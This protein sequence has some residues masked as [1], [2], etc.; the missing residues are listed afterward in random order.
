MSAIS[1]VFIILNCQVVW[2]YLHMLQAGFAN[3][4]TEILKSYVNSTARHK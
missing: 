2:I 4:T 1:F 3:E